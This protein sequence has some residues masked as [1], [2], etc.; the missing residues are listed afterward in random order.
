MSLAN[1]VKANLTNDVANDNSD[2]SYE[3]K[4]KNARKNVNNNINAHMDN[5]LNKMPRNCSEQPAKNA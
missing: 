4:P 3:I 2:D 1:V 5:T